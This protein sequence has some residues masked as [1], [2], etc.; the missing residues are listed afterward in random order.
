MVAVKGGT[1]II[2]MGQVIENGCFHG[3]QICLFPF[4][5]TSGDDALVSDQDAVIDDEPDLVTAGQNAGPEALAG[6]AR[7][8]QGKDLRFAT[9]PGQNELQNIQ[10]RFYQR[11]VF[12]F[13]PV[14]SVQQM[15]SG[16]PGPVD[17]T[18]G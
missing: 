6:T 8:H 11:I 2:A 16:L 15:R 3:G 17:K 12:H 1:D 4:G 7:A 9:Q 10:P 13:G 14:S 18:A 5:R